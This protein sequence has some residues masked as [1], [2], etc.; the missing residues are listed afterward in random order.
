MDGTST[1]LED[2]TAAATFKGSV[3]VVGPAKALASV[4]ADQHPNR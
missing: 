1:S 4:G 2:L 3:D